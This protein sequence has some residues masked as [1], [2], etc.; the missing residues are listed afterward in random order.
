MRPNPIRA[1]PASIPIGLGASVGPY[2][3]GRNGIDRLD[4]G[5]MFDVD[6][7]RMVVGAGWLLAL[8]MLGCADGDEDEPPTVDLRADVN[9]NGRI[10]SSDLL[11]GRCQ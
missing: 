5:G 4:S 8:A 11:E 3:R 9:R 6:P 1:A 10:D 7:S 2:R